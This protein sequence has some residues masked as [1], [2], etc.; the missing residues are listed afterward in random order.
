MDPPEP[1]FQSYTEYMDLSEMMKND[2]YV[3]VVVIQ[4]SIV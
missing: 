2:R 1:I 4:R 3:Q